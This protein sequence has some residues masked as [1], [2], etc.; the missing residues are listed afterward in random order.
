MDTRR[1]FL[2]KLVAAG[3]IAPIAGEGILSALSSRV[4]GEERPRF[5]YKCRTMS[6]EHLGELRA[7][8][9]ELDRAGRLSTNPKY[10][11]YIDNKTCTLP[12]DFKNAK[13]VVVVAAANPLL[14][15]AFHL[16][17]TSRE[18]MIP[19]GYYDFGVSVDDIMK[20][21]REDV[22]REPRCRIERAKGVFLKQ[23][24]VRTGLAEY[25]RNNITYVDG[26]GSFHSLFAFLTDREPAKDE[27]RELRTMERC[28]TCD[29]CM[30]SCPDGCITK[31]NFVINAGRC[32][33]LYN[34]VEG[35][36]PDWIPTGAHNSLIGCMRCQLPCPANRERVNAA[37]RLEDVAEDETRKILDGKPDDSLFA[38]LERKLR[39]FE[40]ASAEGFP[41]FSRNL[42]ALIQ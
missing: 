9:D 5:L 17:G 34:E 37:E 21:L 26:M 14:R 20:A 16:D 7:W 41:L 40:L 33:T 42:K 35:A 3:F 36:F 24:A 22:I 27:W 23:M 11:S 38:S 19:P 39:G 2:K 29:I 6:V 12:D 25:G 28:A 32:L 1:D 13:S 18:T 15:V 31:E 10:R 4:S 8:V 30:K